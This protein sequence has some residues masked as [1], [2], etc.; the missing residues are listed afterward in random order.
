MLRDMTS[1]HPDRSAARPSLVVLVEDD[2]DLR[3]ILALSLTSAGYEVQSEAD[4]AA[5]LEAVQRLAPDLV[6]L[7]SAL[8]YLDGPDVCRRLRSDPTT[9]AVSIV[10]VTGRSS[11]D[12]L[13]RGLDAG[14]DDYVVK[15]FSPDQLLGRIE[16]VLARSRES[17]LRARP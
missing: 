11:S 8:P 5:G 10:I 6:I 1:A 15:P 9:A 2:D 14:A 3:R 7:D 4:G 17:G 13:Q 12:D 16:A